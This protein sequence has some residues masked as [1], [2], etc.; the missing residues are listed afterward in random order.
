M[1]AKRRVLLVDPSD[2]MHEELYGALRPY[3]VE[4]VHAETTEAAF[5]ECLERAP[6]CVLHA[7]VARPAGWSSPSPSA[8]LS[9][10]LALRERFE[11]VPIVL[12][13]SRRT[14]LDDAER[15]ALQAG[16]DLSACALDLR[17][18]IETTLRVLGVSRQPRRKAS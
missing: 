2:A 14:W 7:L 12:L 18:V 3:G 5:N 17:G 6:A 15:R 10:I 8:A 16:A 13:S 9:S 4:V 11:N 1:A